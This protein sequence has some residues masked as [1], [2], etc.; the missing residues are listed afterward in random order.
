MSSR[1]KGRDYN[2][3]ALRRLC[4]E[5]CVQFCLLPNITVNQRY[6]LIGVSSSDSHKGGQNLEDLAG[7]ERMRNMR[8]FGLGKVMF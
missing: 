4:L 7:E 8:L 5:S 6:K 3:T 1:S 2:S